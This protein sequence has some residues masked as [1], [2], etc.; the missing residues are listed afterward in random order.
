MPLPFKWLTVQMLLVIYD[1]DLRVVRVSAASV[2]I[3]DNVQTLLE[4]EIE[5]RF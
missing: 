2:T 3:S 1:V 4:T 5:A